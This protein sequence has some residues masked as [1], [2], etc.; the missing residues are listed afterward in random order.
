MKENN[1]D[2]IQEKKVFRFGIDNLEESNEINSYNEYV[3]KDLHNCSNDLS[4]AGS[5]IEEFAH[6]KFAESQRN[7]S[8]STYSSRINT[9]STSKG[10][11][12][13][14]NIILFVFFGIPILQAIFVVVIAVITGIFGEV[15]EVFED[16]EILEEDSS[17]YSDY[18]NENEF[19]VSDFETEKNNIIVSAESLANNKMIIKTENKNTNIISNVRVQIIFYDAENK[20]VAISK[21]NIDALFPNVVNIQEVYDAPESFARYDFLIT[22]PYD[23]QRPIINYEDIKVELLSEST[24]N[25]N[26]QVTN[27]TNKE[28]DSVEI[29]VIYYN[30]ENIIDYDT[31]SVYDLKSGKSEE[32]SIYRYSTDSEYDRVE[33]FVNDVYIYE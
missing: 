23:T 26:L 10:N 17:Y 24:S 30:G 16:F 22:K 14:R 8:Y 33:Y 13:A 25:I 4:D 27:N 29:V 21:K 1:S 11:K 32:E 2:P 6:R 18:E 31:R 15:T 28:I 5:R 7:K 12:L 9:T 3:D 19:I 20:P